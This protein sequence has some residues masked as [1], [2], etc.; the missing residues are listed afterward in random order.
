MYSTLGYYVVSYIFSYFL[1]VGWDWFPLARLPLT[2]L[3]YRVR[4]IDDDEYGA[5][6]GM[7]IGRGNWSARRKPV[8][9]LLFPPQIPHDLTGAR[10][11]AAVVGSRLQS[12][13]R[14]ITTLSVAEAVV[15]WSRNT[16]SIS[17]VALRKS[18]KHLRQDWQCLGRYSNRGHL[19]IRFQ[20]HKLKEKLLLRYEDQHFLIPIREILAVYCENRTN[21]VNIV[22]YRPIA[23]QRL[24]KHLPARANARNIMTSIARQRISKHA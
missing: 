1:G 23:R 16:P 15:A 9:V 18:M 11:R 17:R 24:G 19:Q 5:V 7:K 14:M 12:C 6:G 3:L 8:P 10:T 4:M 21:R 2:G 13:G 20:L 22:T